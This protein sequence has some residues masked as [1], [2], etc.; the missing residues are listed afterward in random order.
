MATAYHMEAL[1]KQRVIERKNQATET[2]T[3]NQPTMGMPASDMNEYN[4]MTSKTQYPNNSAR[5]DNCSTP[6]DKPWVIT[7]DTNFHNRVDKRN[8]HVDSIY[9]VMYPPPPGSSSEPIARRT[10]NQQRH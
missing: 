5:Y 9:S 4:A 3:E 7:H 6:G 1:R 8:V 2:F 10:R